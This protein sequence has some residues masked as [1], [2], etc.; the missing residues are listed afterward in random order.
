MRRNA[1]AGFG[2]ALVLTVTTGCGSAPEQH[3]AASSSAEPT[4]APNRAPADSAADATA[5]GDAEGKVVGHFDADE[6]RKIQRRA[7][8]RAIAEG[9]IAPGAAQDLVANAK[10]FAALLTVDP[11]PVRDD[12]GT[13]VGYLLDRFTSTD[14]YPARLN[15]ARETLEQ[16][17]PK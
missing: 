8:D 11:I 16:L 2:L 15:A 9:Y 13:V 4:T 17:E 3:V 10:L 7:L 1:A 12:N 14:E 5:V 6:R